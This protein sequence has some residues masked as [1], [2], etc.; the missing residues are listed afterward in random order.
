MP[1]RKTN[2]YSAADR[3]QVQSPDG[4]L[5][6]VLQKTK[7]GVHVERRQQIDADSCTGLT[8]VH[9]LFVKET[10][11]VRFCE[12]DELRFQYPLTYKLLQREFNDLCYI[13]I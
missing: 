7:V 8:L 13:N 4:N 12:T 2:C 5:T 11:F 10:D 3:R 1:T 6:F 9:S